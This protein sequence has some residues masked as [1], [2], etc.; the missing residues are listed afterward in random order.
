MG[1]SGKKSSKF[2]LKKCK[3]NW[4]NSNTENCYENLFFI[5]GFLLPPITIILD[6]KWKTIDNLASSISVFLEL[7]C[8]QNGKYFFFDFDQKIRRLN[9]WEDWETMFEKVISPKPIFAVFYRKIGQKFCSKIL[10]N[11]KK[12]KTKL[13]IKI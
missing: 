5:F 10:K 7:N 6:L 1:I 4:K 3:R 11:L 13:K 12:S 2:E 8:I 9:L